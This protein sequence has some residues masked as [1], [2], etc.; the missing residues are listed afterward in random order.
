METKALSGGRRARGRLS[1]HRVL[2]LF[3]YKDTRSVI[4]SSQAKAQEH[5]RA[6]Q[7]ARILPSFFCAV[8]TGCIFVFL[9]S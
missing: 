9:R 2:L 5:L 7:A 3:V 8:K 4:L 6:L 1:R